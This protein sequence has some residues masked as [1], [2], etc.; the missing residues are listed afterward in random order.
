MKNR[1]SKIDFILDAHAY[2]ILPEFC[3]KRRS[4]RVQDISPSRQNNNK[5]FSTLS[6]GEMCLFP[7]QLAMASHCVL[8]SCQGYL[9]A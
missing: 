7:C 5:Q 2:Q 3:R 4:I 8:F 6:L 1:S 9:I